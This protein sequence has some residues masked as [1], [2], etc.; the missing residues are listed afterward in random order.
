MPH[1]GVNDLLWEELEVGQKFPDYRYYVLPDDINEYCSLTGETNP[2]Y[3]DAE[4]AK[5]TPFGGIVA[6]PQFQNVYGHYF[7]ILIAMGHNTHVITMHSKAKYE[8]YQP[9]KP[10]DT[11]TAEM[12]VD[13]KYVRRDKKYLTWRI[14]VFNQRGEPVSTK[15]HTSNWPDLAADEMIT[16]GAVERKIAPKEMQRMARRLLQRD[17]LSK[18]TYGSWAG[19]KYEEK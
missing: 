13:D 11:L 6:P 18:G 16:I 4:F 14:E 17:Y 19:E 8:W 1:C 2:C 15:W 9:A 12:Y 5:N 3:L 7:F 10:G